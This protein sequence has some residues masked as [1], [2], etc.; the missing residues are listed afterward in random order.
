MET[1][2]D[3]HALPYNSFLEQDDIWA[4]ALLRPNKTARALETRP[5]SEIFEAQTL[6]ELLNFEHKPLND[7]KSEIRVVYH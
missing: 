2:M 7:E 1:T 3:W 5:E 6:S 4:S